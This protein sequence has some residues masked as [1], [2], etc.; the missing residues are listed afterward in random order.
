MSEELP[1]SVVRS[2]VTDEVLARAM[3]LLIVRG[4]QLTANQVSRSTS[5][6]THSTISTGQR[7]SSTSIMVSHRPAQVMRPVGSLPAIVRKTTLP[8]VLSLGERAMSL[9]RPRDF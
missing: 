2:N 5:P 3:N 6:P 1:F 7:R 9:S 4:G 8:A